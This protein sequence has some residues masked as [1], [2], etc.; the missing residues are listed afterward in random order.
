MAHS[1]QQNLALVTPRHVIFLPAAGLGYMNPRSPSR[2]VPTR[3]VPTQSSQA[4]TARRERDVTTI[5]R[6]RAVVVALWRRAGRGH[7]QRDERR[8]GHGG[9]QAFR[10][11]RRGRVR[12][13]GRCSSPTPPPSA[14]RSSTSRGLRQ[15]QARRRGDP[16]SSR[17]TR[18][19]W[20]SPAPTAS[21]SA[22]GSSAATPATSGP[23]RNARTHTAY[24][25]P[26]M[27]ESTH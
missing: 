11:G 21:T 24:T 14:R 4:T 7:V 9:R 22:P 25:S 17:T 26:A 20:P 18:A 10:P 23:T 8:A 1:T 27:L 15:P 16:S 3:T 2:F 6:R 5:M 12:Q 19:A 13:E